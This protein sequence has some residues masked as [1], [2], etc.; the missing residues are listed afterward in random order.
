[1]SSC[2]IFIPLLSG[3]VGWLSITLSWRLVL[4][5]LK[6]NQADWSGQLGKSVITDFIQPEEIVGKLSDIDLTDKIGPILSDRV[7]SVLN[8]FKESTPVVGMFLNDSIS[9]KIKS[10]VVEEITKEWPTLQKNLTT[11]VL[12]RI[13]L[14]ELVAAK[15]R[16]LDAEKVEEAVKRLAG[17]KIQQLALLAGGL[18]MVVGLL[19]MGVAVWC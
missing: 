4:C 5:Y 11:T 19:Q 6:K 15:L 13:N 7:D 9:T 17:Q 16:S 3:L 1:M 12:E 2:L 14:S 8:R 10:M 18:G